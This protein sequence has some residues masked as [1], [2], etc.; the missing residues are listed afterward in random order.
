[1]LTA[2]RLRE[3]QT[4]IRVDGR[5][6]HLGYFV[7]REEAAAAYVE[8]AQRLHGEFARTA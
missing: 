5:A 8:A 2:E 4:Y 6:V 1:M 7:T 3:W